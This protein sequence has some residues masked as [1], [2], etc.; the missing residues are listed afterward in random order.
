MSSPNLPAVRQT[1]G[2]A[3]HAGPTV[4][5][6]KQVRIPTAGKIRPGIMVLT[7]KGAARDGAKEAYSAGV[8]AGKPWG[9]IEKD[10]R[11]ACK[12][13]DKDPSPLT[14]K[15][16]PYFTVRR[17][18]FTMP[19][20]A[21]RILEMY[22]EDRG[23][24]R[25]LYRFPL[26]LPV[27]N[28]QAVLPH[29]LKSYKRAE[30]VYWSEYGADNV[31]YCMTMSDLAK[32]EKSQRHVRPFGGR[33][34]ALRKENDGRCD[35]EACPQYQAQPQQCRL[36]GSFIFYIPEIPGSGAIELPMTSFYG[37]QGIRQ[38][39]ELMGH[40]RGRISG[41]YQGKA[42][43]WLAKVQEEVSMLDMETGKAKRVKQWI[44]RL[45]GN[46][47]MTAMLTGPEDDHEELAA[48]AVVALEGPSGPADD[49]ITDAEFVEGSPAETVD[50]ETGEIVATGDGGPT[51]DEL[52]SS[53]QACTRS[54]RIP[55][56]EFSTYATEKYLDGWKDDRARLAKVFDELQ[57]V[58]DD[59]RDAYYEKI[60]DIPF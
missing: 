52:K 8:L 5:G 43:F 26:V 9:A 60:K 19:E 33:K 15:N 53:I 11:Q 32:D 13:E 44:T 46:V 57:A 18:D 39:L 28:W 27:D 20:I 48:A 41:T 12:M 51:I 3:I 40:I 34:P 35:P 1:S 29:A 21:D 4:L 24:G 59:G 31:R 58:D 17:T 37:L 16:A 49:D 7:A 55:W 54:L 23:E 25:H 38:Q 50:T 6:E 30:L 22:G 2:L 47:D 42:M 36:S 14:P 56:T 45:E 10:I